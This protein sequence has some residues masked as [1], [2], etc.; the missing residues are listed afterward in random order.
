MH[1][2]E[3]NCKQASLADWWHSSE[4]YPE[5]GDDVAVEFKGIT[6]YYK[7]SEQTSTVPTTTPVTEDKDYIAGDANCDR[8]NGT[9][10][11][12]QMR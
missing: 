2:A 11:E 12:H 8:L 6:L 5:G 3:I 4:K 1:E 7:N 9:M 10:L